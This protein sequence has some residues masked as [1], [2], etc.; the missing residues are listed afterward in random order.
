MI[1]K[2]TPKWRGDF[3]YIHDPALSSKK[4]IDKENL[5]PEDKR[6]APLEQLIGN[7]AAHS[8]EEK[9]IEVDMR[10]AAVQS[11]CVAGMH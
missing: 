2:D 8:L 1:L 7:T 5:I 9:Q 4:N 3:G 11:N 10:T 6:P